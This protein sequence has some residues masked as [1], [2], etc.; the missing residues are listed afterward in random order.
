MISPLPRNK[1]AK[2]PKVAEDEKTGAPNH[3]SEKAPS[4]KTEAPPAAVPA[5][6]KVK[7]PVTEQPATDGLN[8]PFE[9]LEIK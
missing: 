6:Q 1:R 5:P 4:A 7:V 3:A 8:S 2:N 9:N